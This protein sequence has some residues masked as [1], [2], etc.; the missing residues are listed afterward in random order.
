MASVEEGAVELQ[1][2]AAPSSATQDD[3]GDDTPFRDR[4]GT[5]RSNA[6]MSE[7]EEPYHYHYGADEAAQPEVKQRMW[8]D[9]RLKKHW[10]T[11]LA[12]LL[13]L[14]AGIG[15]MITAIVSEITTLNGP[16]SFVFFILAGI[17]LLP[18]AYV[19][20]ITYRILKGHRGYSFAMLPH[21]DDEDDGY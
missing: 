17:C 11:V 3:G 8:N 18:G 15:L 7:F 16:R 19:T 13:L 2:T 6:I 12:G 5:S 9:P 1:D 10:Q 14:A 20:V 21:Y 4:I